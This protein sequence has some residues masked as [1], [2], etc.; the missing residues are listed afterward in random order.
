M[1]IYNDKIIKMKKIINYPKILSVL[2]LALVCILVSCSK[3]AVKENPENP[4]PG[5]S[6]QLIKVS[7]EGAP[8]AT[9]TTLAGLVTSW[10]ATTDK[11][12]IY[13]PTARTLAGGS[14]TAIVN[15]E[16]TA[17]SSGVSSNFN[18]TMYW[19]AASTSHTFYA[20]YPYAA[21]S[22]ESTVVPVSLAAAQIQASA[23]SNAHLGA[24]D[25][26]VATPVTV[27]SPDNTDAVANEVKF[28]YNHLFA[29][30]E[31]QIKGTGDLKAVK[32]QGN[33]TLAFSG[34]TIDITQATPGSGVAYT[35]AGLTG[36]T[37][38]AVVTLTSAATLTATN[39]DTKVYMVINPG[40]PTGSC[41][42]GVSTDGTTWKYLEKA[43][44]VGGFKRGVKYV[45][46][47][48]AATATLE[49][50]VVGGAG[51][52]W[53]D[54]NL[55]ATRVAQ[56]ST[57]ADAYGD[58]YQ[59]G[60]LTDGHQIRTSG[61]TA[62]LADSDTPGHNNFI[63]NSSSPFDWRNPQNNN[64]WQGASGT[65]NPCPS[66]FRLPTETELNNERVTWSSNNSAGAYANPLKFTAA[67]MRS[68]GNGFLGSVGSI[69]GY[70]SSTIV[71][72]S[73]RSLSFFSIGAAFDS[74]SRGHG[75]SVRCI[76]D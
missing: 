44:P 28:R 32:L 56:S 42:V 69:G 48:D 26:L 13:S 7:G 11:V 22:P 6:S 71:G 62:T 15:A 40:T 41:L 63:T 20:Y 72:T 18:G 35:L 51:K 59:W 65:N 25:F 67:G 12:G 9:K 21:G 4:L 53:M 49:N 8:E 14:G 31:F 24:L 70:W 68:H 61:I 60:R 30:L 75:F 52:I 54:R 10:V 33:T 46:T 34:G 23:N 37:N 5:N 1:V 2:F 76:K 47:I 19:G 58:L 43:V 36:T 64:L 57:D 16:F 73:S 50:V 3:D 17:A 45:V 27:T 66:G 74:S 38:E 39:A 55:G 29:I